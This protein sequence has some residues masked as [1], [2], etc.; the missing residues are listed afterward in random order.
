MS[1]T[2][3]SFLGNSRVAMYYINDAH[4]QNMHGLKNTS[5][6]YDLK[7]KNR[8][9]IDSFKVSSGDIMIGTPDTPPPR[10]AIWTKFLNI[11]GI[12]VAAIGNHE[13]EISGDRFA[14]E[15]EN[16][17]FKYLSANIKPKKGTALDTLA[18]NNVIAKSTTIER[19]GEVYGFIGVSPNNLHDV[20]CHESKVEEEIAVMDVN[21]TLQAIQE[22]VNKLPTD[23]IFLL[24]HLGDP[25]D[26]LVTQNVSGID[27]I[28]GGH[29][30]DLHKGIVPGENLFTSPTGDPVLIT[31]AGR[32]GNSGIL[33]VEF[34]DK[35]RIIPEKSVNL[36]TMAD[37]SLKNE[38]ITKLRKDVLGDP[39]PITSLHETLFTPQNANLSE[40]KVASLV[41]DAM[42]YS[43]GSDIAFINSGNIRG[44]LYEGD[45]NLLDIDDIAPFRQTL[46]K[47][48]VTEK[49]IVTALKHSATSFVDEN[50]KPGLLQVAGMEYEVSS[51]GRLLKASI[52]KDDNT[53]ETL[54]INNP[55]VEKSYSAVYD[56]FLLSGKLGFDMLKRD[57]ASLE[58][59]EGKRDSNQGYFNFSK[60]EALETYLKENFAGTEI[61]IQKNSRIKTVAIST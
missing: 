30:H 50:K 6:A 25:I 13:L 36:V 53:K 55:S 27:V 38:D 58:E 60:A 23:R 26:K 59:I 31:Q 61:P 8:N 40:N 16:S 19:N 14:K 9:D 49:D 7:Y 41:A 22:E 57:K 18:K 34:D 5:D 33:E 39:I 24:S 17:N 2:P 35:G 44:A 43:T 37:L 52:L 11:I 48:Q 46:Y 20:V 32:D 21:E 3:V 45:V 28:I 42:K 1:G 4:G 54:N 47:T 56:S 29:S 51:D 12:D 15:V 10:T